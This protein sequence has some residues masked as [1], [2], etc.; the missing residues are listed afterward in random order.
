MAGT[1]SR[2]LSAE[3]ALLP[4]AAP[5]AD[6]AR[7]DRQV[8]RQGRASGVLQRLFVLPEDVDLEKVSASLDKGVLKVSGPGMGPGRAGGVLAGAV[9]AGPTCRRPC[10]RCSCCRDYLV[11][12]CLPRPAA[13]AAARPRT[14]ALVLV[15]AAGGAAQDQQGAAGAGQVHPREGAAV[16]VGARVR[17]RR[18]PASGQQAAIGAPAALAAGTAA[19]SLPEPNAPPLDAPRCM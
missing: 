13:A 1:R 3:P 18:A 15:N 16:R 4:G 7:R 6:E 17:W 19:A 8:I 5:Q 10:L 9:R 2:C 12:A 14:G 11:G